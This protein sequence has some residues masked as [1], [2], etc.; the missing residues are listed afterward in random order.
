MSRF[1]GTDSSIESK[2]HWCDRALGSVQCDAPSGAARSSRETTRL[3]TSPFPVRRTAFSVIRPV[4][5]ALV[6]NREEPTGRK[7][8]V[9]EG[10]PHRWRRTCRRLGG[11][12]Y[13][14]RKIASYDHTLP[15]LPCCAGLTT[16]PL[17]RDHARVFCRTHG[18][19]FGIETCFIL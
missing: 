2:V 3:S 19:T 17:G 4:P 13:R 10:R 5:E 18:L 1:G 15:R 8:K 16:G 14:P 11:I 12:P 9:N 6:S 7:E